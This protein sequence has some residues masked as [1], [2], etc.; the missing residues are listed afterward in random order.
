MGHIF[1]ADGQQPWMASHGTAAFATVLEGSVHRLYFSPRDRENRSRVAWLDIDMRKPTTVLRVSDVPVLDIGEPGYFDDHGVNVCQVVPFGGR[2]LMYYLGWNLGV[3]TPFRNAIGLAVSDVPHGPFVKYSPAP[4][5][6]RSHE[7]PLT[8]S[9]PWIVEE[10]GV[11]RMWYGSS[12]SWEKDGLDIQ[13]VIKYAESEDGINWRRD[14]RVVL[15][16]MEGESGLAR[17]C[18]M[19]TEHGYEMW[20]TRR[21][22][23]KV[24][25]RIGYATSADGLLWQRRDAEVGIDVSA[26]GWDSE[27]I[28]YPCV[29]RFE[30]RD[31]MLY[32]GNGFGRTGFGIAVRG[33]A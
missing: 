15:P 7:D 27:M 12:L 20:Y 17:P 25:C 33:G 13:H 23:R 28:D 24:T 9:T 18:V 3:T 31:Y 8:L 6:D 32:N 22:G 26:S 1:M 29:F 10:N 30:G 14:G 11:L 2:Y 4:V 19:K 5:L 21:I 16:L